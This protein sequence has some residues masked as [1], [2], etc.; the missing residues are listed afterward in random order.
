MIKPQVLLLARKEWEPAKMAIIDGHYLG[1][2]PDP[3][4]CPECYVV[5]VP[6]IPFPVGYVTLGRPEAQRCGSWYGPPERTPADYEVTR[7]QVL[8]LSRMWLSP[9]VQP[10]GSHF[11]PDLL[12]GF[13]DRAGAFRSTLASLTLQAVAQ[14]LRVDY[15]LARPPVYLDEPYQLR[16]LLSYCDTSRH[17]GTIYRAAGFE[18]Y[19]QNGGP[20]RTIDT[21]RLA[22]P[23]L[24]FDE[25]LLVNEAALRSPRSQRFRA[26]RSQTQLILD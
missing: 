21:Y 19:R 26:A 13:I 22:L 15:L 3:R 4:S 7:W 25:Q 11:H 24:T 17:R 1:R 18:L 14:A 5:M 2:W 23:A 16:Y 8:N 9:A 12:P 6:G 10:G 20:S